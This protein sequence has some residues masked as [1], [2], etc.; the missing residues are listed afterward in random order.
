MACDIQVLPHDQGLDGTEFK[1]FQRIIDTKAV[2][3]R[4]LAD[5]IEVL[6][7]EPLLLHELN[8]GQCVRRKLDG[9][10]IKL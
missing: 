6:L 8:V 4:V 1:R 7:D 2:F 10:R 5:L 9:L 3:V